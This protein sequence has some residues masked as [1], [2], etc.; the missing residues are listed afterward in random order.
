MLVQRLYE[1]CSG[2][3]WWC[4]I[5]DIRSNGLDISKKVSVGLW[6]ML[7][8]DELG[9]M[10]HC[11]SKSRIILAESVHVVVGSTVIA[12]TS[13]RRVEQSPMQFT[14]PIHCLWDLVV[15]DNVFWIS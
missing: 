1:A 13:S 15:A 3:P 6:V 4:S 14:N 12:G 2:T 7:E 11:G 5:V 9:S 10:S 8:K